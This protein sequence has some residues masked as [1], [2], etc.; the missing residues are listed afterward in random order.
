MQINRSMHMYLQ[1]HSDTVCRTR[2]QSSLG[3]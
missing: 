1:Q 2:H 3:L